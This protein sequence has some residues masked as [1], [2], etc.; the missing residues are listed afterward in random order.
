MV[1]LALTGCAAIVPMQP[2]PDAANPDC[3]AVIVRV[4]DAVGDDAFAELP[5]RETDAQGTAAWGDP[6]SVLLTCGVP[7]PPPSEMDCV[8]V[9]GID[10]LRDATDESITYFTTYGRDP[11]IMVGIDGAAVSGRAVLEDLASSIGV[12]KAER[13]CLDRVDVLNSTP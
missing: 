3:A 4:P 9:R 6:V 10:W 7:V 12:I 2:G 1:T 5:K 11:A 13:S 8:E